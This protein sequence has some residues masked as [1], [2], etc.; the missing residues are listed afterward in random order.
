MNF[1]SFMMRNQIMLGMLVAVCLFVPWNRR[2][3]FFVPR[4]V[5]A[6]AGGV[7][8]ST[9]API[10]SPFRL[11]VFFLYVAVLVWA[12]FDCGVKNVSFSATC[13]YCVQHI[14]SKLAYLV[15]TLWQTVNFAFVVYN[16]ALL[17]LGVLLLVNVAVCIP[18]YFAGTR[19]LLTNRELKFDS[20]KTLIYTATFVVVAVFLSYYAERGLSRASDMFVMAYCNLNAFCALFA[21]IIMLMNFNNCRGEWLAEDKRTLEQLLKKDKQQYEIAKQNMERINIRYHDI[22]QQRCM[23]MDAEESAKLDREISSFKT[24]YYTGNKAVDITLSE[25]AAVCADEN[26]QFVCSVDGTCLDML[27][28]YHIYSLLGN[29]IDNAVECLRTVSDADKKVLRVNICRVGNMSVIRTENYVPDAPVVLDGMPVTTKPDKEN[30]GFGIKSIKNIAEEYGGIMHIEV[31]GNV[32]E[33][34]VMIP[35]N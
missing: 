27:K 18:V 25:K 31:S 17:S 33:L 14:T 21:F 13:A 6:V 16:F 3:S 15:L 32:F 5:V 26:I 20:L 7:C 19:R 8:L 1:I 35:R 34:V 29:A 10:P 28:P 12:C 30:H 11:L 4:I 2:R 24:L 22:K 9:F 23:S